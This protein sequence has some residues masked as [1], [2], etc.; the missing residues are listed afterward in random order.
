MLI[1]YRLTDHCTSTAADVHTNPILLKVQQSHVIV[2][3]TNWTGIHN[4]FWITFKI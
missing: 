2:L 1:L 4:M 3:T